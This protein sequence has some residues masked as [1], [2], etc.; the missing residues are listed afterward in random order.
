MIRKLIIAAILAGIAYVV[1]R[2]LDS[3]GFWG[4]RGQERKTF[5]DVEQ[6]IFD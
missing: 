5:E 4:A 3:S 2:G 1:Y 6:Q